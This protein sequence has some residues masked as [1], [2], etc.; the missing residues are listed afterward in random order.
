MRKMPI[1]QVEHKVRDFDSWKQA[2]DGDP[3]GRKRAACA[4][5]GSPD[6][7]TTPITS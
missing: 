1:F 4:A 6:W 3:V 5:T 2:F 7:P